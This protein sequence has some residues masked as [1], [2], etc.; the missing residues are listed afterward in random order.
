MLGLFERKTRI[1]DKKIKLQNTFF[2]KK[3]R[4]LFFVFVTKK[5]GVVQKKNLFCGCLK[6]I[7]S[8]F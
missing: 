8:F 1:V 2:F 6:K 5:R 4:S 3:K 7:E